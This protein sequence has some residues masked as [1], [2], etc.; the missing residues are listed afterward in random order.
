[1]KKNTEL[2]NRLNAFIDGELTLEEHEKFLK[3]LDTDNALKADLCDAHRL[4][5]LMNFAY[6]LVA[7]QKKVTLIKSNKYG[8]IAASLLLVLSLGFMGGYLSSTYFF[9]KNAATV[10]STLDL[11]D[12]KAVQV[13][14]QLHD[15][16][17]DN[18]V[19][20]YLGHSQKEKFTQALN[21]AEEL[22]EK[23]KQDGTEVY[24][25]TSAGGIDLLR[26]NNT[27]VQHRIKQMKGLHPSLHFVA[28]NNQIYYLHKKGQAVNLVK[29]AEVAP[30]AVQFVVDHLKNGW[31]YIAI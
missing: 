23:Y 4:K 17:L 21:K 5:E 20:I 8:A 18:K 22:L 16:V 19:I 12:S 13:A 26:N 25:V 10:E 9:G 15:E 3:K 2:E 31:R 30:S 1:M 11:S 24:V 28:C 7:S 27:S 6:P 14:S 29:E